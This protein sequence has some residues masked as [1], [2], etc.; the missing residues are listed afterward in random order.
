MT[1]GSVPRFFETGSAQSPA[2]YQ[3]ADPPAPGP[4]N[5][6]QRDAAPMAAV[7]FADAPVNPTFYFPNDRSKTYLWLKTCADSAR[8]LVN[9]ND[10]RMQDKALILLRGKAAP[11]A[12]LEVNSSFY[13]ATDARRMSPWTKISET[14]ARNPATGDTRQMKERF[15]VLL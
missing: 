1:P 4:D 3:P 13:L 11:F 8:N 5:K 2:I 6:G 14:A 7:S 9:G 10:A 12:A 15:I